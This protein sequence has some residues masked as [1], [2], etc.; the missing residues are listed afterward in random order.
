[1]N[2]VV[3]DGTQEFGQL[4]IDGPGGA[5][6]VSTISAIMQGLNAFASKEVPVGIAV[7]SNASYAWTI[8]IQL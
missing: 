8:V 4:L 7:K 2:V 3:P 1:M 6:T 5:V